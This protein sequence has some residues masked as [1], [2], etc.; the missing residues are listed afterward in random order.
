MIKKIEKIMT[1]EEQIEGV[2]QGLAK[3]LRT[4]P[5]SVEFKVVKKPKGIKIIHEVTQEQLNMIMERARKKSE[6]EG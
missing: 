4:T 3:V 5:F 6:E 2:I 1:Q